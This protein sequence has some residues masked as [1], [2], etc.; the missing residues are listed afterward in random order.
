MPLPAPGLRQAGRCN[1][2]QGRMR[3]ASRRIGSDF[4][5]RRQDGEEAGAAD[6]RF[7]ASCY[8]ALRVSSASS[9]KSLLLAVMANISTLALTPVSP[10][11]RV[12]Y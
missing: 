5:P 8:R 12:S 4:L 1:S 6:G 11:G 3:V 10:Q 7:S 2:L 9:L